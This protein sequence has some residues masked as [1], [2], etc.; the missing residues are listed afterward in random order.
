M[1]AYVERIGAVLRNIFLRAVLH[2]FKTYGLPIASLVAYGHG[3]YNQFYKLW[4]WSV[5][6]T[7][8]ELD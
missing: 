7:L 3:S 1:S 2:S 5:K 6:S 4:T 8:F